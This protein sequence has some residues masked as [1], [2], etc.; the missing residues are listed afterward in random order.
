[1]SVFLLVALFI[2]SLLYL[3]LRSVKRPPGPGWVPFLGSLPYLTLEKGIL[4]W[5]LDRNVT[6]QKISTVYIF[7]AKLFVIND[8]NLAKVIRNKTLLFS[9]EY[10]RNYLAEQNFLEEK[11][12][13]FRSKTGSTRMS[14]K[15]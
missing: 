6:H 12:Q 10:F 11:H 13:V 7:R 8:F 5:V 4:D 14:P 15:E 2:I 3:S 1:M 9:S